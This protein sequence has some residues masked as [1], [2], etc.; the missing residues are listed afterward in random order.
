MCYTDRA[1]RQPLRGI[2]QGLPGITVHLYLPTACQVVYGGAYAVGLPSSCGARINP[3]VM[4]SSDVAVSTVRA[5]D[6]TERRETR[7]RS[8]ACMLLA[9]TIQWRCPMASSAIIPSRS[10]SQPLLRASLT[11]VLAGQA[12]GSFK[13]RRICASCPRGGRHLSSASARSGGR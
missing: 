13:G 4:M 10:I 12:V 9:P 2:T 3:A 8:A 5:Q 7:G 11:R 1:K 6:G